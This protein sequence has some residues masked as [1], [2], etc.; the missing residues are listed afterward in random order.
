MYPLICADCR[1]FIQHENETLHKCKASETINLVTGE[2]SYQY[3]ITERMAGGGCGIAG[4]N[5]SLNLPD[6]EGTSHGEW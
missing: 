4:T 3:C 2:R 5:F 6:L 1:W